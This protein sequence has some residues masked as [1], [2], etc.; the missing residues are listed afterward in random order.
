MSKRMYLKV[1]SLI[2]TFPLAVLLA[3]VGNGVIRSVSP[4][5]GK[6]QERL[7]QR[8]HK[9]TCGHREAAD[10]SLQ[11]AGVQAGGH[12]IEEIDIPYYTEKVA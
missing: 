8:V 5:S 12:N 1:R 11:L 2:L 10:S 7:P 3:C 4:E 6:A 9:A